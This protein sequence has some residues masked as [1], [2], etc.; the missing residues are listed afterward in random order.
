MRKQTLTLHFIYRKHSL[1]FCGN[2]CIYSKEQRLDKSIFF[3]KVFT[4]TDQFNSSLSEK[5]RVVDRQQ[6]PLNAPSIQ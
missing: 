2:C 4:P 1:C 3:V 6:F 5:E